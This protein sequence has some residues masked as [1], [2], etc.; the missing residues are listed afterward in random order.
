MPDDRYYAVLLRAWALV[1]PTFAEGGGSFPVE[2]ALWCGVPVICSDIPVVRE[3][4]ERLGA[5][6]LWFD[7]LDPGALAARLA[8]LER[9]YAEFRRRAVTQVC[10]LRRR[11][12]AEVADEYRRVM[13]AA[14]APAAVRTTNGTQVRA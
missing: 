14:A 11:T 6:V 1:M 13:A 4:V 2:E 8:E 5:E 10:T 3:H 9:D 7:P 12:W